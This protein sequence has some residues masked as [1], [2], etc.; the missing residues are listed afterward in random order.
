MSNTTLKKFV[1]YH[2]LEYNCLFFICYLSP[3]LKISS[4]REGT[5]YIKPI[6]FIL[7]PLRTLSS[8]LVNISWIN[9]IPE[10]TELY[11]FLFSFFFF[12]SFSTSIFLFLLIFIFLSLLLL[13][14][15]L[16]FKWFD[17]FSFTEVLH[18][19]FFLIKNENISDKTKFSFAYN[20]SE[21]L[22]L[23]LPRLTPS[24]LCFHCPGHL[25]ERW[26]SS[27]LTLNAL[28]I[29]FFQHILHITRLLVP[30]LCF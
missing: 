9:T 18:K 10:S 15:F 16:V 8:H 25:A 2:Y 30:K 26:A 22:A 4:I 21:N 28:T 17:F 29:S 3:P 13:P 11:S 12:L 5:Y 27:Y 24:L 19:Y 1:T 20:L 23:F 7:V 6:F 14:S